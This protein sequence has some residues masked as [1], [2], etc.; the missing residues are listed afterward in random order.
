MF[1]HVP[2]LCLLG[3]GGA[4]TLLIKLWLENYIFKYLTSSLKHPTGGASSY[5]RRLPKSRPS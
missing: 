4:P 1:F 2:G 5:A 3:I